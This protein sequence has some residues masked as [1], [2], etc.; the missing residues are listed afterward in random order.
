MFYHTLLI[1]DIPSDLFCHIP[2]F[3]TMESLKDKINDLLDRIYAPV[4]TNN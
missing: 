1:L 2:V 3:V 4:M